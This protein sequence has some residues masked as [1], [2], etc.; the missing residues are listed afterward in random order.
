MQNL[1]QF[2][3]F[4]LDYSQEIFLS[5]LAVFCQSFIPHIQAL[6]KLGNADIISFAVSL[7]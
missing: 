5:C 6:V 3:I 4:K 2:P 1:R 7:C